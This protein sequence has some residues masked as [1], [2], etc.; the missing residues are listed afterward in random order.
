MYFLSVQEYSRKWYWLIKYFIQTYVFSKK[1]RLKAI[2]RNL[3]KYVASINRLDEVKSFLSLM[4]INM[5]YIKIHEYDI[6]KRNPPPTFMISRYKVVQYSY[7]S[8]EVYMLYITI[9]YI[10]SSK[11]AF[12]EFVEF[13]WKLI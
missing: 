12:Q 13:F 6:W 11:R 10:F 5:I 1:S 9:W 4:M 2:L 7:I 8:V 3:L